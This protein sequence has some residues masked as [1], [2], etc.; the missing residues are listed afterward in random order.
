LILALSEPPT[1]RLERTIET[2]NEI[3]ATLCDLTREPHSVCEAVVEAA[4]E[5]FSAR[6]VA[7]RFP[8]DPAIVMGEPDA[9]ETTVV[10]MLLDGAPV[11]TLTVGAALDDAAVAVMSTLANHAAAAI[12][13]A[14]LLRRERELVRVI[15]AVS[16]GE[17]AF[18][19][20][21]AAE[22]ALT[23]RER[24]VV[25]LIA[26]G[27]TNRE[28]GTEIYVSENTVKFHVRNVMRKLRVHHRAEV[29][30]AAAKGI[31]S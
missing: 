7:M 27:M 14:W 3:S 4:A 13:T 16:R 10:P 26:R 23:A 21:S 28:I 5:Q 9:A 6:W 18:D 20:G 31:T 30:Y 17:A 24:Q 8:D 15:R 1:E 12:G 11:G 25:A 2:L 19:R 29:A 22:T